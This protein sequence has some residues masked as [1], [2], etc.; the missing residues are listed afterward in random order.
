[1]ITKIV[2][3]GGFRPSEAGI[4]LMKAVLVGS[5]GDWMFQKA[6]EQQ[7]ACA[8]GSHMA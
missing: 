1:V 3:F 5:N 7:M 4:R 2:E 8:G 6:V